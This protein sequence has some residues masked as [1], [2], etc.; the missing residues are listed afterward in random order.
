MCMSMSLAISFRLCCESSAT[1]A[2]GVQSSCSL[3]AFEI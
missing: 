2:I 3:L 1:E